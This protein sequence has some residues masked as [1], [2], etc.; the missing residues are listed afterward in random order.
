[1]IREADRHNTAARLADVKGMNCAMRR[2]G[3]EALLFHKK[4]GHPICIEKDGKVVWI[5]PEE[6]EVPEEPR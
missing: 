6:I 5:P 3:R 4:L 1:M 2:A